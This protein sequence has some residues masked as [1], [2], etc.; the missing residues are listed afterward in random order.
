MRLAVTLFLAGLLACLAA[1]S[2]RAADMPHFQMKF[3]CDTGKPQTADDM[4]TF[5][6]DAATGRYSIM[7]S[8]IGDDADVESM[9]DAAATDLTEV[10]HG[11]QRTNG[12]IAANGLNGRETFIDNTMNGMSLHLRQFVHGGLYAVL[13]HIGP[14]ANENS[15]DAVAFFAAFEIK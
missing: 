9:F 12:P 1:P 7:I 10:M 2:A 11:T 15:P 5:S 14:I 6:C 3:P 13:I 8:P 4:T